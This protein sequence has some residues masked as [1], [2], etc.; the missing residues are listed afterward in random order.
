MT[1]TCLTGVLGGGGVVGVVC[2]GVVCVG[3]LAAGA[4]A[5]VTVVTVLVGAVRAGA[6]AGDPL[7]GGA[8]G[9]EANGDEPCGA[10]AVAAPLPPAPASRRARAWASAGSIPVLPYAVPTTAEVA[11]I[12]TAAS[13]VSRPSET[14]AAAPSRRPRTDLTH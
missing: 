8:G 6:G 4:G 11:M 7:D 13:R 9:I 14:R 12:E 10:A 5:F 3:V 1:K 2:V